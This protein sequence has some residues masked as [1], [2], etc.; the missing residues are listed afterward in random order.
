MRNRGARNT[1]E[2][3]SRSGCGE[4]SGYPIPEPWRE[5]PTLENIKNILPTNHIKSF[6][7]INLE[8]KC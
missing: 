5:T 4:Q 2:K 7:D 8:E 3:H 6:A 1:I